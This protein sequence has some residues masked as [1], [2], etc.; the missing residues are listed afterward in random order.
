MKCFIFM[1][2]SH[3]KPRTYAKNSP[4]HVVSSRVNGAADR[5]CRQEELAA[6]QRG[7]TRPPG[8]LSLSQFR[9]VWYKLGLRVSREEAVALFQK[10]GCDT[11]GL[12]PYDV[13]AAKLLGSAARLLA[14][15]PQQKVGCLS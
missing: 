10:F 4:P 1:D 12:L 2:C 7:E 6:S 5:Q 11:Q 8:L 14:L 9:H 15:E 3:E 13:F